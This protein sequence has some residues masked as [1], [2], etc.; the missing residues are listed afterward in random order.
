[1]IFAE[2]A[3]ASHDKLLGAIALCKLRTYDTPHGYKAA[4][5]YMVDFASFRIAHVSS[6]SADLVCR[7]AHPDG[8][9][10]RHVSTDV[11][12][13]HAWATLFA[14]FLDAA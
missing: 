2:Q 11:L 3:S 7:W 6:A 12:A 8:R 9:V 13:L 14:G 1:L 10:G 4:R 5:S